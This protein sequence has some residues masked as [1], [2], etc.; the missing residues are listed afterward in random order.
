MT[1]KKI[2]AFVAAAFVCTASIANGTDETALND[3]LQRLDTA[4]I[5]KDVSALEMLTAQ[6]LSYGHS[7]GRVQ[8]R[9]TFLSA[10]G[11]G[12]THNTR[13][14]LSNTAVTVSGDVAVVR[15]H[16]SG[17]VEADGKQSDVEFDM[18]MTWQKQHGRWVLLARQG[19]KH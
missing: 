5:A 16:Y 18:L 12:P 15:S 13:I 17:T 14:D 11:S 7:N 2:A 3:A 6:T 4:I 19:Y 1:I 9:A 8:D 10:I